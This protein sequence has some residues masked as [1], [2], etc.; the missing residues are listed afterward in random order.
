MAAFT[1]D[2]SLLRGLLHVNKENAGFLLPSEEDSTHVVV[3]GCLLCMVLSGMLGLL[4]K[5]FMAVVPR[6]TYGNKMSISETS[7]RKRND[8]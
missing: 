4:Q 5:P 8:K 3:S 7:V 2:S 6:D 1:P